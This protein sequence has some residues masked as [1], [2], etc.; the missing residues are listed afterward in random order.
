MN[1]SIYS[2]LSVEE[3]AVVDFMEDG[4]TN[5]PG[6]D[7]PLETIQAHWTAYRPEQ[8]KTALELLE[9][10]HHQIRVHEHEGVELV[11]RLWS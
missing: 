6:D 2:Q 8:L 4:R 3:Q 11:E 10:D 5:G 7:V 9:E 1:H